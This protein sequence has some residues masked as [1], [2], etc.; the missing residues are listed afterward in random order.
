MANHAG[1]WAPSTL[2]RFGS[3]D[4]IVATGGGLEQIHVPVHPIRTANLDPVVEAFEG[5]RLHTPG[6]RAS[7]GGWLL[8]FDHERLG[9]QLHIFLGP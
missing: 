6:D 1:G 8:D 2:V 7:G 9:R 3:L 4:F 5:L